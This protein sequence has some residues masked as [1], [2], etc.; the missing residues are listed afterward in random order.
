MRIMFSNFEISRFF[1]FSAI[2]NKL[3]EKSEK[4]NE[5]ERTLNPKC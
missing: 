3:S 5:N 1:G 4:Q 2:D